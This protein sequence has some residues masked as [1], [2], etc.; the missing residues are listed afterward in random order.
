MDASSVHELSIV[1]PAFLISAGVVFFTAV[2][3]AAVGVVRRRTSLYFSFSTACLCAAVFQLATAAYY[4]ADSAATAGSALQ[5]QIASACVFAPVFFIFV[6]HYTD[7]RRITPWLIAV[8]APF[9]LL[10][11]INAAQP[12]SLH[13]ST[14]EPDGVLRLPWGEQLSHFRG[15]PG[16]W[17][18]LVRLA[19]VILFFWAFARA[20][21]QYRR[22]ERRAALFLSAYL[23]LQA[24]TI[25]QGGLIDWG[26]IRSVYL[27]GFAFLALAVLMSMSLGMELQEHTVR[28]ERT[29]AEL[30]R[31]IERRRDA[32]EALLESG[33]HL[34]KQS[35][36]LVRLSTST[37]LE[38]GDLKT[39][40]NE[41]ATAAADT[42]EI[43]RVNIWI[44]NENR[45]T[46]HCIEMYERSTGVHSDGQTLEAKDYPAYFKALEEGRTIAA[47]DAFSDPRT[48]ELSESYL[49]VHAISSMLDAPIRIEGRVAGVIC[50]EQIGPPRR[51]TV[52]DQNFVGSLADVV[53]L[54]IDS[55][56]RR[57]AEV[58][59]RESE[60]RF[61]RLSEGPFE[62]IAITDQ[63]RILDANEQMGRILGY[64]QTE[65]I[66][67]P[68]LQLVA[69]ESRELVMSK[70]Q[71]ADE[72]P[73]E[74]MAQRKDGST[75][76]VEVYGR[77]I[78]YKGRMVRI[79][80]IRD[81]T[82]RKRI[83]QSLRS[84]AEEVKRLKDRL[85]AENIY[86]QDE[87]KIEHNFEEI[88]GVSPNFVSILHQVEQVASTD[89]T[90]LILG[91]TG[92]G[93]EL[94]AR[95]IHN[96][97]PR[98]HRTLVKVNCAALPEH[99]IESELFGHEK[100][101]FTGALTRTVGRFELADGGTLFLDEIGDLPLG[102]QV[103][104]LRV[105]QEGEFERLGSA[106]TQRV[107][108]RMIAATNR[109]LKAAVDHG[110]FRNDLYFRLNVF[111]I[112]IPP[113]RTRR[114]DIPLLVKHFVEKYAGRI[115]K[116]IDQISKRSMD[117]LCAYHWP[118]NIRELENVI[119]RAVILNHG[120]ILEIG[121]QLER[122]P[123][124]PPLPDRAPTLKEH[125][126]TM[127]RQALEEC[128]WVIEG[129][130][131]AAAR[132]DMAPSTLRDRMRKYGI[133]KQQE[134]A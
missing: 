5:W 43:E 24:A 30:R 69:P 40:L 123:V 34:R 96:I 94:I 112:S 130:H 127:I 63:G 53:A 131:G 10:L 77:R 48:K 58:A 12:Y 80:A 35:D 3:S 95:A 51:W 32:E 133:E 56:E 67:M 44:Y 103:K 11:F 101:A 114:E 18:S 113:L 66:G 17:N 27:A 39:V 7:Q 81:I 61:R 79:T 90:V 75:F 121:E 70:I 92:T 19:A 106:K 76:P 84:A 37:A 89:S 97:S 25:V 74:H 33:K 38:S 49:S 109:D 98:A 71:S 105:L 128:Q 15:K 126:Q 4:T 60:E 28:L 59:L 72:T 41:I 55:H 91:E 87:I 88:I 57:S 100:G 45:S 124:E 26:V 9:A 120:P 42:L 129:S 36:V 29:D 111:P 22:G 21:I 1:I 83:E 23:I 125:E 93:K 115:G 104:L 85:E 54:A 107:D 117:M 64:Q 86:L 16:E 8:A 118:G 50:H 73:Y 20:V 132:L 82:E 99:L 102:L 110:T 119:E 68:V 46:I 134:H 31:E 6:S 47:D 52:E 14:L 122:R 116:E 2:Q 65:L 78:P 108:V 62:G 13:Y